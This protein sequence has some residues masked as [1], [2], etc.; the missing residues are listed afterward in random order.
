MLNQQRY[1]GYAGRSQAQLRESHASE[2]TGVVSLSTSLERFSSQPF[3]I[4]AERGT[5]A[6]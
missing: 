4:Y 5:L 2:W 3:E 1:G 6:I